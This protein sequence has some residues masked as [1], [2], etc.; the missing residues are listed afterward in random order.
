MRSFRTI[1]ALSAASAVALTAAGPASAAPLL[2]RGA[3]AAE[4]NIVETAVA[5]FRFEL[6]RKSRPFR[7]FDYPKDELGRLEKRSDEDLGI[8][9]ADFNRVLNSFVL[10]PD[11]R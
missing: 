7:K 9:L 6:V 8:A 4:K 1:V 5:C 11:A 3:P 10:L 2:D